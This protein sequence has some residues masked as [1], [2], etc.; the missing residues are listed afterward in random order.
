VQTVDIKLLS[1]V[2]VTVI[3]ADL[4]EVDEVICF[5]KAE[6]SFQVVLYCS[7]VVLKLKQVLDKLKITGS[8]FLVGL[9]VWFVEVF[10]SMFT[11]NTTR[12]GCNE[13]C[14]DPALR[15]GS[16][17]VGVHGFYLRDGPAHLESSLMPEQKSQ[18][19]AGQFHMGRGG[20]VIIFDQPVGD[21]STG[22]V[23]SKEWRRHVQVVEEEKV[24]TLTKPLEGQQ[25]SRGFTPQRCILDSSA[26]KCHVE[27][28]HCSHGHSDH[29]HY[30]SDVCHDKTDDDIL[31]LA[32]M[33]VTHANETARPAA[34]VI[35]NSNTEVCLNTVY[36]RGIFTDDEDDDE[37]TFSDR[38]K[39]SV[40]S[41]TEPGVSL[42]NNSSRTQRCTVNEIGHARDS[43]ITETQQPK[44]F[45]N[46]SNPFS[47]AVSARQAPPVDIGV[48]SS[49]QSEVLGAS[50]ATFRTSGAQRG[51]IMFVTNTD[52]FTDANTSVCESVFVQNSATADET[53]SMSTPQRDAVQAQF[54]AMSVHIARLEAE[55]RQLRGAS[56][57]HSSAAIRSPTHRVDEIQVQAQPSISRDDV[58]SL[59]TPEA[60]SVL[61]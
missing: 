26:V 44:T 36:C 1:K 61:A 10:N 37:I 39:R 23:E 9:T 3:D 58:A 59:S 27:C 48:I 12:H 14:A 56:V 13:L 42:D 21:W 34:T 33:S 41:H 47:S 54:Q 60:A 19:H 30:D 29:N 50:S 32:K 15:C 31:M 8:E 52:N 22:S 20:D 46:G 51:A 57:S 38:V 5:K 40:D 55:M 7:L 24:A 45:N 16:T 49:S 18:V 4:M 6:N 17:E 2:N 11:H 28:G 43:F 35:D 25:S 53:K